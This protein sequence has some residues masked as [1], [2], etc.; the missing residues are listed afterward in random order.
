MQVNESRLRP[1]C[2]RE[3]ARLK[4]HHALVA[5]FV[6][7]RPGQETPAVR[8][9]IPAGP[10]ACGYGHVIILAVDESLPADLIYQQVGV[11]VPVAA[12]LKHCFQQLV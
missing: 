10:L 4:F 11:A 1:R 3:Q 12:F 5:R 2:P 7:V 6:A 8:V 9:V